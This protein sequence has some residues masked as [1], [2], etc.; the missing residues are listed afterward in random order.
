[1]PVTPLH[2]GLLPLLNRA[3]KRKISEA[4]FVLAN[5]AMDLPVLLSVVEMKT[6][7]YGGPDPVG[8]LHSGG[9][10]TLAGAIL[11]GVVLATLRIR[12]LGWW[13]GCL[14]GTVTHVALDMLVHTDVLPFGPWLQSNPFYISGAHEVLSAV[15]A[16]GVAIWVLESL[17]Q[18]RVST[19]LAQAAPEERP[20]WRFW[21]RQ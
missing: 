16:V 5:C 7:E 19:R 10:H 17:D 8:T 11:V 2:F 6:H 21:T 14:L 9:E 4:G 15:L 13:L 1:M 3:T 18:R 20:F 12:H